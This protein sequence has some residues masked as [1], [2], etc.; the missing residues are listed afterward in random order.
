MINSFKYLFV[1]SI[2]IL[3]YNGF[4]QSVSADF[5]ITES[6][7]NDDYSSVVGEPEYKVAKGLNGLELK[8]FVSAKIIRRDDMKGLALP[9]GVHGNNKPVDFTHGMLMMWEAKKKFLKKKGDSLSTDA[10]ETMKR[11]TMEMSSDTSSPSLMEYRRNVIAPTRDTVFNWH[12][13]MMKLYSPERAK[14]MDIIMANLSPNVLLGYNIQE[15]IPPKHLTSKLE[16]KT[17]NPL[18]KSYYFDRLLQEGGG[19]YV[20][21][22]PARYDRKNSFGPFQFTHHA[23]DDVKSNNRL[24][25]DFRVYSAMEDLKTLDDHALMSA[26]FAYNN[27]ERMSM[28][29]KNDTTILD[30]VEYFSDYKEDAGKKKELRIFIAGVTACMHHQPGT[31]RQF[32]RKFMKSDKSMSTIYTDAVG[33][34]GTGQMKKYYRSS[35]EAYLIM[36]VYHKLIT[37]P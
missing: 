36:K 6:L 14:F 33:L 23:L 5:L 34:Y 11:C 31:A 37:S 13:K 8:D 29:L 2:L 24:N 10:Q 17:I 22:F 3:S 18:F 4:T 21:Y 32:V 7:Y 25:N 12:Q 15:L 20:S 27:W 28:S 35:A 9:L 1:I 16:L 26:I 30:F 19:V